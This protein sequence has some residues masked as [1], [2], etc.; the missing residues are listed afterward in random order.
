MS[1]EKTTL[2]YASVAGKLQGVISG[3]VKYSSE[4]ISP[5]IKKV[6]EIALKEAQEDL[7]NS[8]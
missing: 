8:K 2:A 4:E 5:S 1:L 6:L 3:I 7:E